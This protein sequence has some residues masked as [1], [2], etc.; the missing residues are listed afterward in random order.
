MQSFSENAKHFHENAKA[1]TAFFLKSH[2]VFSPPCPLRGSVRTVRCLIDVKNVDGVIAET[3]YKIKI[4]LK[5]KKQ[6]YNNI[7]TT[8]IVKTT[9]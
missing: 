1:L 6:T 8:E 3:I 4:K 9:I 7:K 2:T 5:L